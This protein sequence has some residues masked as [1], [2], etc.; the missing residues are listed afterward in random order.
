MSGCG[1]DG[2]SGKANTDAGEGGAAGAQ[3]EGPPDT[4]FQGGVVN[5]IE[6]GTYF[7]TGV[8]DG[9]S[10]VTLV[11]SFQQAMQVEMSIEGGNVDDVLGW[12]QGNE[13]AVF[14]FEFPTTETPR[15]DFPAGTYVVKFLAH[16]VDGEFRV[17]LLAT[18]LTGSEL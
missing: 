8:G 5:D 1:S 2:S 4:L 10:D 6:E 16:G 15:Y 14:Y 11:L 12:P 17:E 9:L 18:P 13:D 3:S 7:L